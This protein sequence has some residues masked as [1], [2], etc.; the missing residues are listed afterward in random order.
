MGIR[1]ESEKGIFPLPSQA[2]PRLVRGTSWRNEHD[3][4]LWRCADHQGSVPSLV[5]CPCGV[6]G[7]FSLQVLWPYQ[8]DKDKNTCL[9]GLWWRI[10]EKT[11][12]KNLRSLRLL[13]TLSGLK[14]KP[15]NDQ[16]GFL[17]PLEGGVDSTLLIR[18]PSSLSL[19]T[20]RW[21]C[22]DS[23]TDM[24]I[25]GT[26]SLPLNGVDSQSLTQAGNSMARQLVSRLKAHRDSGSGR[27]WYALE[28]ARGSGPI[29][30]VGRKTSRGHPDSGRSGCH[31]ETSQ[32]SSTPSSL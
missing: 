27:L 22:P 18:V 12:I 20:R 32:H 24:P 29:P 19:P 7:E 17:S 25:W 9:S 16:P 13:Q 4:R 30:D 23:Q 2:E 1:K 14:S 3:H 31:L 15:P 10:T 21:C 28:S 11:Q 6:L 5:L 26:Q 8:W